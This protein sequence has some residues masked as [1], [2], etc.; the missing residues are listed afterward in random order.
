M[1][2]D[3]GLVAVIDTQLTPE[4]LATGNLT[5]RLMSSEDGPLTIVLHA[6]LVNRKVTLIDGAVPP[7]A[8]AQRLFS[9][10][11]RA[12]LGFSA[13]MAGACLVAAPGS[14]TWG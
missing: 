9:R 3:Q 14:P 5:L 10:L 8:E 2:H 7:R 11:D 13:S 1:A 12:M 6:R 4:L